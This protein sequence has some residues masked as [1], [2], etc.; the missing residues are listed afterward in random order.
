VQAQA[1]VTNKSLQG[2]DPRPTNL[3]NFCPYCGRTALGEIVKGNAVVIL[4]LRKQ[5]WHGETKAAIG[6]GM[7]CRVQHSINQLRGEGA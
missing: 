3:S 1:A 6:R 2:Y 7:L 4:W 5:R